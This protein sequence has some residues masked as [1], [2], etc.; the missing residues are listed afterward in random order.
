MAAPP[1]DVR[2]GERSTVTRGAP[3]TLTQQALRVAWTTIIPTFGLSLLYVNFHFVARYFAHAQSF[4]PFGSEWSSGV[5]TSAPPSTALE[6]AEISALIVLDILVLMIGFIL[7]MTIG[8]VA[9]AIVDQCGFFT[10]V[11]DRKS[12]VRERV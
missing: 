7:A 5:R 10:T 12:V 4:A 11:G 1:A 6:Y 9:Y 2:T 8:L 3:S